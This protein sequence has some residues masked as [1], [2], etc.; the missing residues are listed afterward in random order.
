MG[1]DGWGW[2]EMVG[3]GVWDQLDGSGWVIRW[4]LG[5]TVVANKLFCLPSSFIFF[6]VLT[7]LGWVLGASGLK[8][9]SD[10]APWLQ[11]DVSG[12]T[13]GASRPDFG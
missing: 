2:V 8:L 10:W 6:N 13:F 3:M 12:A 1:G 4:V 7:V 9:G 5:E 11:T